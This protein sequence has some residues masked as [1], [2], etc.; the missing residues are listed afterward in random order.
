[1]LVSPRHVSRTRTSPL[2]GSFFPV[3]QLVCQS[4]GDGINTFLKIRWPDLQDRK[5]EFAPFRILNVNA[6]RV[7]AFAVHKIDVRDEQLDLLIRLEYLRG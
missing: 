5:A 7:R 2:G 1:M 3:A 6:K 4:R